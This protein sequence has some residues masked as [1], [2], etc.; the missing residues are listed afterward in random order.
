MEMLS[1]DEFTGSDPTLFQFK[2]RV[3]YGEGWSI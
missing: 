3:C 1:A 2:K